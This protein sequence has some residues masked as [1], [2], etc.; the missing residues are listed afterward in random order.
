MV[1]N[2]RS[3]EYTSMS[4]RTKAWVKGLRRFQLALRVFHFIAAAGLLTLWILFDKVDTVTAWVMRVAVSL[5]QR[6]VDRHR[7]ETMD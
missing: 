5:H 4:P 3:N 7:R 2:Y 6:T 1:L